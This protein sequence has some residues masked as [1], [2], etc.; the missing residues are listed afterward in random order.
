MGEFT[1]VERHGRVA[2]VH[3]DRGDKLNALSAAAMRELTEVARSFEDD[4]ETSA[5]VLTGTARHF[6]AGADLSDPEIATRKDKGLLA[7]R[8]AMK[9]GPEMCDAWE[10]LEQITICAVEGFCIGGG[11]AL[12]ASCD[13][14]IAGESAYFRLPEIPLGMNMSWHSNPRLVNLLGPARAKLFIIL[15]EKLA[16]PRALEWGL[17]EEVVTDGQALAAALALAQ[18]FGDL[19]PLPVRMSKQSIDMAAKALNPAVTFMDRDQFALTATSKDQQE[20]VN[21]FL[22]KR[23]PKFTG[24]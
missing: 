10:R 19:P 12:A 15:G 7:R 24:E 13:I 9:V 3:F 23:K 6:S 4:L 5:I 2:T 8:H 11:S 22:E 20:A 1:R 17:V 18:K 21:A 16:A 14:R